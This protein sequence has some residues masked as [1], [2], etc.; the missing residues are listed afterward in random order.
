[1][2]QKIKDFS[3]RTLEKGDDGGESPNFEPSSKLEIERKKQQLFSAIENL[4]Y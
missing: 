2:S 3:G 4:I 1:M